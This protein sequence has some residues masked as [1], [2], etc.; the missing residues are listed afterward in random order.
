MKSPSVR[1]LSVKVTRNEKREEKGEK[2]RRE[3]E[4]RFETGEEWMF[5]I[6]VDGA[7]KIFT[8]DDDVDSRS[9]MKKQRATFI[10]RPITY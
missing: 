9:K 7:S 1:R 3:R 5:A 4:V 8:R 10:K 2:E 6:R